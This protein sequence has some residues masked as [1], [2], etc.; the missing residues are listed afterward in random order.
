MSALLRI[1]ECFA[2]PGA[3]VM[4]ADLHLAEGVD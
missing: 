4:I 3:Q 1:V 2:R